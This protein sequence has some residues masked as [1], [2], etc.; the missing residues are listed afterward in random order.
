MGSPLCT[1]ACP[2]RSRRGS[3][4]VIEFTK[5]DLIEKALL[6]AHKNYERPIKLVSE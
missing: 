6:R 5:S 3:L 4:V 1:E 2:E